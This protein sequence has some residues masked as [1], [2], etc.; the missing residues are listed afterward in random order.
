MIYL[1]LVYSWTICFYC[2][3]G[4]SNNFHLE[5]LPI[6]VVRHKLRNWEWTS[7][8]RRIFPD[9][10]SFPDGSSRSQ[11]SG[12]WPLCSPCF[13]GVHLQGVDEET[14]VWWSWVEERLTTETCCWHPMTSADRKFRL[15]VTSC[16]SEASEVALKRRTRTEEVSETSSTIGDSI[17]VGGAERSAGGGGRLARRPKSAATTSSADGTWLTSGLLKN[18]MKTFLIFAIVNKIISQD[19]SRQYWYT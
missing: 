11:T 8:S 3:I 2:L 1:H 9:S 5:S 18:E 15:R 14:L 4:C 7:W 16:P 12:T 19:Q 13:P 6:A 17:E 10:S